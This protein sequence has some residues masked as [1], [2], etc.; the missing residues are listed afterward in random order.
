MY[1]QTMPIEAPPS[2]SALVFPTV[3]AVSPSSITIRYRRNYFSDSNGPVKAYS[4]IV[5]GDSSKDSSGQHLSICRARFLV[6]V[7]IMLKL[8]KH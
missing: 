8:A 1:T 6:F 2:P 4:V 5:A 3:M 7:N